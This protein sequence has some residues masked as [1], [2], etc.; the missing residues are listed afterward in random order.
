MELG[1]KTK[2]EEQVR[3]IAARIIERESN[4]TA[5]IT[6][7][8]VEI[9]DRARTGTIFFTTLP[10]SGEESALNFIKRLRPEIRAEVK[11]RMNIHT[12]PFLDVEI[13]N[14]EKAR[15]NID[16]LLRQE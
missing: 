9:Y 8:R 10:V 14:G 15:Q 11:K 12:I 2:I 1:R 3:E 13:D 4:K 16:A 6:V 5:L 7:T